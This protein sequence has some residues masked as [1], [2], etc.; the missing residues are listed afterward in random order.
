M[1]FLFL[2]Q[3]QMPGSEWPGDLRNRESSE[4]KAYF[5]RHDIGKLI[6]Q[7]WAAVSAS[8]VEDPWGVLDEMVQARA[9]EEGKKKLLEEE[10]LEREAEE[11][12]DLEFEVSERENEFSPGMPTHP[13]T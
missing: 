11:A 3:G 13:G 1:I 12:A 7:W 9:E 10:R 8:L 6:T 4:V 2:L 5:E